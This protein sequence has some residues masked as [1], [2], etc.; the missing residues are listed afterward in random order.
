VT[1]IPNQTDSPDWTNEVIG[2]GQLLV[3]DV[4]T[5][6]AGFNSGI[7]FCGHCPNLDIY[8][9][10]P[11]SGTPPVWEVNFFG[12]SN[13]ANAIHTSLS[14]KPNASGLVADRLTVLAPYMSIVAIGGTFTGGTVQVAGVAASAGPLIALNNNILASGFNVAL[15]AGLTN[16]PVPIVAPGMATFFGLST[17]ANSVFQIVDAP[18]GT[19]ATLLYNGVVTV[20]AGSTSG[21]L[22]LSYGIP[23]IGIQMPAGGGSVFYS[24]I[25]TRGYT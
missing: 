19:E 11:N 15:A 21:P 14:W 10:C 4:G 16:I 23:V 7:L 18:G 20:A 3:N 13:G 1:N 22:C 17:A 24:L 8:I 9:N 2:G 25:S 6:G 5:A 12:S